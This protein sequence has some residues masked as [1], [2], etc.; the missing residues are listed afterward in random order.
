VGHGK[1][2]PLPS[3]AKYVEKQGKRKLC[4]LK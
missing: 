1:P 3:L 2:I 4:R